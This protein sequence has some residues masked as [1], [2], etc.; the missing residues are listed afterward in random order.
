MV[1]MN[2]ISVPKTKLKTKFISSTPIFPKK[3]F[4]ILRIIKYEEK[5]KFFRKNFKNFKNF[6]IWRKFSDFFSLNFFFKGKAEWT[7]TCA[8]R[9][10]SDFSAID[11]TRESRL[12]KQ[13]TSIRCCVSKCH[14]KDPT[15]YF[16]GSILFIVRVYNVKLPTYNVAKSQHRILSRSFHAMKEIE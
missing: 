12:G 11:F 5:L 6:K 16:P 14:A 15:R 9:F 4:K 1:L 8:Q 7:S 2:N 3:I 10:I 13:S